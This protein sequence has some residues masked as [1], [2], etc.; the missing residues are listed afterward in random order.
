MPLVRSAQAAASSWP[1]IKF[2][3]S[4]VGTALKFEP[5]EATLAPEQI[6]LAA[7]CD[8]LVAAGL[9]NGLAIVRAE[10]ARS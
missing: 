1:R 7:Q 6:N 9:S 2:V 4:R 8:E 3:F 5:G 10:S